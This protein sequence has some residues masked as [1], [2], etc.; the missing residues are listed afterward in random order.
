[1]TRHL[2]LVTMMTACLALC[3]APGRALAQ[4]AVARDRAGASQARIGAAQDVRRGAARD[5]VGAEP[6]VPLAI[7]DP[8][9]AA[10]NPAFRLET[11][12]FVPRAY[13]AADRLLPQAGEKTVLQEYCLPSR[14]ACHAEVDPRPIRRATAS[15]EQWQ[16]LLVSA[17][18]VRRV[19]PWI[20]Q[21]P[22]FVVVWTDA[23]TRR[24]QRVSV[25][26]N[27]YRRDASAQCH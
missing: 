15:G 27:L 10:A 17:D 18:A 9:R 11:T 3:V 4:G 12:G 6:P 13:F 7:A 25:P 21:Q 16:R 24:E 2:V 8:V 20:D 22:C 1:M 14:T 5:A 19:N 23:R 26:F